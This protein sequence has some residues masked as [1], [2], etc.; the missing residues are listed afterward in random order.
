[1]QT[2]QRF[3]QPRQSQENLGVDA[4][5]YIDKISEYDFKSIVDFGCG[6]GLHVK[7]FREL[8]FEASGVDI[9]FLHEA[10]KEAK[11]C[12]YT[13]VKGSWDQLEDCSF[14]AGFSHHCL[15]HSTMPVAWLNSWAKKIRPGGKFF[16]SVPAFT[17]KVMAGHICNGWTI[18]QLAYVLAIAG[19]D[20][21]HGKFDL[22]NGS[23]WGFVDRS[24]DISIADTHVYGFGPVVASRMPLTMTIDDSGNCYEGSPNRITS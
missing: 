16:I 7:A 21:R 1:M 8:G 3:V 5:L 17:E 9:D 10:L 12:G 4:R 6:F 14:D 15:E 22:S 19:F 20:C 2:A 23:V 24:E 11:K 13:L 18:G